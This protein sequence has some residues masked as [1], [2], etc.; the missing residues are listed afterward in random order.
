MY[1]Y[2]VTIKLDHSIHTDWILWM[3]EVHIPAVMQTGC[4]TGS[5]FVRILD[6]DESDGVTYATQYFAE[7]LAAYQ[8]Y[9]ASHAPTLRQDSLDKWGNKFIGFRTL[10]Q[11][12]D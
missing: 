12:V 11:E 10:M 1:I 2:N 9:I 3:K 6:T 4:F 8:Q 7:T 5:K